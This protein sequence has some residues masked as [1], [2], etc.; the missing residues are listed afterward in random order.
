METGSP[1]MFTYGV[2]TFAS[3]GW[4]ITDDKEYAFLVS[5]VRRE[6]DWDCRMPMV[7]EVPPD[8][9]WYVPFTIP[10]WG[11]VEHDHAHIGM[12]DLPLRPDVC[13]VNS[14]CGSHPTTSQKITSTSSS[15]QR[16]EGSSERPPIR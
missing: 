10:V 16:S 7:P 3:C 14:H 1:M 13:P 9:D 8:H 2:D 5:L 6:Q 15:M 4:H 11:V 12:T